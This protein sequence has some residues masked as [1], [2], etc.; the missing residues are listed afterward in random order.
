MASEQDIPRLSH[1][2]GR[3]IERFGQVGST[4]D[5][6]RERARLGAAEGLVITAEEQTAGRGRLG[7][8]WKA[9]PGSSLLMSVLLRPGWLPADSAFTL[10]MLAAVALCE[11]VEACVPGL[12]ATL[13]WP[14]D[15]LLP[16]EHGTTRKAAGIL[17]ELALDG[18]KID[19][20][21]LGIGVN[22]NWAPTGTVD[23]R[24]LSEVATSIS[25]A[26]GHVIDRDQFFLALLDRLDMRY[27]GLRRGQREGLVAA[28]RE[29]LV[30]LGQHVAVQTPG[31]V[32][33]GR[34]EDVDLSGALRVRD[35]AG[36]VHT[37]TAGDV[38]A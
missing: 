30:T 29:R 33:H 3:A 9:P 20:V 28:W 4:N 25:A 15:L 24:D 35:A 10:T 38:S 32:L 8:A 22:V 13:K 7:R 17:S 16:V 19:Y 14:N 1:I 36:T 37:V 21:I 5:M 12:P 6:L 11:A 26:A 2:V 27:H 31:G 18:G 34:A 23:G